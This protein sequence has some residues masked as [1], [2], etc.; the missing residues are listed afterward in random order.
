MYADDD[1]LPISALQ[2][3]IFCER[4]CALIHLEGAWAENRLTAEGR[5]LHERVD[6]ATHES[7]REV[8]TATALRIRSLCLGLAGVADMVE[9]HLQETATDAEG[10]TVAV[11]LPR[12]RGCW[13]PFPVEY[14]RGRPKEHRADEVQLCAQ[15]LCLEEMMAVHIPQGALF[16]GEVRRRT[17]VAFDEGLRRLTQET[18]DRLHR[19]LASG[20]TPPAVYGKRCESCSLIETCLPESAGNGHSAGR[21]L[22]RQLDA[23]CPAGEGE[24]TS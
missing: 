2:H 16:Y 5:V 3:L 12:A 18:A 13:A 23:L 10:R 19:L 24:S 15:A 1:L 14:K 4:Q 11:A 17:D 6:Q 21:W 7:R 9:F 22:A 20:I 8:R